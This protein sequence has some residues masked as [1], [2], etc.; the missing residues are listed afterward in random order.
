VLLSYGR[1]RF[2]DVGD[3]TGAP[4]FGLAC[5][6]DLIGPVDVYLVAHHGNAD[7]ADPGTFAAFRPR[8]AILNTGER[9]GGA[10][11]L[12]AALRTLPRTDGGSCTGR[13]RARTRPTSGSRI[14]TRRRTSG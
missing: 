14:R 1:F 9:K 11:A 2:L 4:L 6:R 7:A 12:L 5:P 10:P 3:L 13:P 8:V